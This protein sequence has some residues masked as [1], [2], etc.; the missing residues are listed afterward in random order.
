MYGAWVSPMLDVLALVFP[1]NM[2][3]IMICTIICCKIK[4]LLSKSRLQRQ[5]HTASELRKHFKNGKK[6]KN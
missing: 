3:I 1:N 2:R 6:E 5:R 4:N